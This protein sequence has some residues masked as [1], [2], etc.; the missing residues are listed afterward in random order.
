M[1][2][3]NRLAEMS[4]V[5]ANIEVEIPFLA[6]D[7]NLTLECMDALTNTEVN[8]AGDCILEQSLDQI[9]KVTHRKRD[10]IMII[11][12]VADY[13]EVE[14]LINV[15]ASDLAELLISEHPNEYSFD[16]I[17]NAIITDDYSDIP[18][19]VF[20]YIDDLPPHILKYIGKHLYLE[21]E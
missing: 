14:P 5:N 1:I 20:T 15:L 19:F 17:I 8:V 6:N 3:I 9:H 10:R 16:K 18:K 11:M 7:I 2:I 4:Q 21:V 12:P 13:L